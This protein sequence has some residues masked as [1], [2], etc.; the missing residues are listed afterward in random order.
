MAGGAAPQLDP[1]TLA[2]A[3]SLLLS[4][5]AVLRGRRVRVARATRSRVTR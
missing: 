2:G 5:L 4:P 1:A 3:S